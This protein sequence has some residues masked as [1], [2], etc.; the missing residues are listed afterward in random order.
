MAWSPAHSPTGNPILWLNTKLW[1]GG[2][3]SRHPLRMYDG[4]HS[5]RRV[6]RPSRRPGG[7]NRGDSADCASESPKTTKLYDCTS[8]A[9]TLHE[10][11]R[12][13]I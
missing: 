5:E 7:H 4:M 8:H 10:V 9:I 13:A 3:S 12:I 2:H 1:S 6:V 11:E